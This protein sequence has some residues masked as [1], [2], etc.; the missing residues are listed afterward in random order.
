MTSAFLTSSLRK[1]PAVWGFFI[2]L[3]IVLGLSLYKQMVHS[4]SASR[5]SEREAILQQNIREVIRNRFHQ[6]VDE[7][8][9]ISTRLYHDTLLM[10]PTAPTNPD[11][12]ARLFKRLQQYLFPE[13]ITVDLVD[14]HGVV[15]AW[16]GRAIRSEYEV[17]LH[18]AAADTFLTILRA[19]LRTNLMFGTYVPRMQCYILVSAPLEVNYPISN[20]FIAPSSFADDLSRELSLPMELSVG[21]AQQGIAAL[22]NYSISLLDLQGKVLASLTS[23]KLSPEVDLEEFD[24]LITNWINAWTSF[25]MILL[26]A[27]LFPVLNRLRVLFR[28]SLQ[29]LLIWAV[30]YGWRLLDFPSQLIGGS[31]FSSIPFGS[32][33]GFDIVSS[34]GDLTISTVA[35]VLSVSL[36][37][38]TVFRFEIRPPRLLLRL[39]TPLREIVAVLIML[40]ISTVVFWLIRGYGAALRSVV[41]DSTINYQD[42]RSM[43]PDASLLLMHL[44]IAAVTFC[45]LVIAGMIVSFL[46]R[47]LQEISGKRLQESVEWLLMI[48]LLVIGWLFYYLLD[49]TPQVSPLLTGL[50]L[51]IVLFAV[52]SL[53]HFLG[54]KKILPRQKIRYLFLAMGAVFI[55]SN[56]ILDSKLY[57]REQQKIEEL[58]YEI[59]QPI[60]RW[61]SF[62]VSDGVRSVADKAHELFKSGDFD[63]LRSSTLAFSLWVQTQISREG[64]NSALYVYNAQRREISRF[65]VGI[66][67][68]QQREILANIFS[69]EEE[70]LNVQERGTSEGT[71]RDYGEWSPLLDE[72]G[73]PFGYVALML[74]AGQHTLFQG[75]APAP[76]RSLTEEK[77][78]LGL[79]TL[80]ISEYRDGILQSTTDDAFYRGMPLPQGVPEEL[81]NRGLRMMWYD[82]DNDNVQRDILFV[83]DEVSPERILGISVPPLTIRWYIYNFVKSLS[84]YLF[85]SGIVLLGWLI[86]RLLRGKAIGLDFRDKLI[87]TF[88]LL[89]IV[90][91]F[92]MAYYNRELAI[93]RVDESV[94]RRLSRD[95]DLLHQRI[96]Q[97]IESE[98]DFIR[99]ITDDYCESIS[100]EL[101]TDFTV[102]GTSLVHASSRPELFK[103]AILDERLS[104]NAFVNAALL[105][106]EFFK[107]IERIGEVEYVV[108]YRPIIK[109]DL[110]LGVL[111]VAVLNRQDEIE[112]DIAQRNAFLIGLYASVLGG[113]GIIAFFIASKLSK[114]LQDLSYAAEQVGHGDLSVR[115]TPHSDDEVGRLVRSFNTMIE[116]LEANRANLARAERELAWKEMAKQVAHEI[117]NPLTPIKLS[118]QHLQQAYKDSVAEFGSILERVSQTILDQIDTLTR[119]AS[120]FSNFARMPHR[121]FERVDLQK[122][123]QDTI[124]LFSEIK[125]VEFQT[126]IGNDPVELIADSDELRRVFINLFRNSIQAMGSNGMVTVESI[127]NDNRCRI[128]ITD[129]GPG[130]PEELQSKVFEPNFSTKTEG[131]GLGL[132]ICRKI[133]EDLN[134]TIGIRSSVRV[135]TTI[136]IQI[137]LTSG[138][139]T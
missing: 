139:E 116:E 17:L 4:Y 123:I 93:E 80:S 5:W 19:D 125:G 37:A 47:I 2:S 22:E 16:S 49:K 83:R 79:R 72:E 118:I 121:R 66:T 94:T 137:P 1:R 108:G 97:T 76:L 59:S 67:A 48:L 85:Y 65:S 87:L 130:I 3:A 39:R 41:F 74:S 134:G 21:E 46:R 90:P 10:V 32:P 73:R 63:S 15:L 45:F 128:M 36:L 96:S 102:Y 103:A 91:L 52:W 119:I 24:R 55:L 109:D 34:L 38:T 51:G 18:D 88:T 64:Y 30:R 122:I 40:V 112:E 132:A 89:A 7:L 31:L 138:Y 43:T 42:P 13:K 98:E 27:I 8:R 115:I 117:K 126:R 61:H 131:M 84:L 35:L 81:N 50:I 104:A 56:L 99:G 133:I 26:A 111:S 100:S 77:L 58:A 23:P 68:Y 11:D 60:D 95:L 69:K 20:R 127:V 71:L 78:K 106:R 129:T 92:V 82:Y 6:R 113:I 12:L 135:G 14:P 44:N 107:D 105:Q 101:G 9:S 86:Q 70:S 53:E 120:E 136:E 110:L 29:I 75:E 33:F 25:A 28:V 114:P 62:L 124:H 54:G 57:I